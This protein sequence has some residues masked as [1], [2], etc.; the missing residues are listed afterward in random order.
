[1]VESFKE[2]ANGNEL[3]SDMVES[4]GSL[5]NPKEDWYNW[6]CVCETVPTEPGHWALDVHLQISEPLVGL[7][8]L[9]I[10]WLDDRPV[11]LRQFKEWK[12]TLNFKHCLNLKHKIYWPTKLILL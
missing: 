2:E 6:V 11:N 7:V 9:V 12:R 8:V 4:P 5:R 10:G 3:K 1:M